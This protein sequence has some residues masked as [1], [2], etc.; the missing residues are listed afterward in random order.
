MIQVLDL[1]ESGIKEEIFN[2]WDFAQFKVWFIVLNNYSIDK[3]NVIK[4]TESVFQA[5]P[6]GSR[7]GMIVL[8]QHRGYFDE[9]NAGANSVKEYHSTK[10]FDEFGNWQYETIELRPH[11][12]AFQPICV[13]AENNFSVWGVVTH[14]FIRPAA[15][16]VRTRR[17][18]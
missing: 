4:I 14:C 7:Q 3:Q 8:A 10:S 1:D 18:Q 13:T 2:L 16:N 6:A 11:N 5:N 15:S 12:P 17:L 9:D